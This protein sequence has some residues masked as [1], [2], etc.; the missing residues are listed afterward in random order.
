MKNKETTQETTQTP[1][2]QADDKE[3]ALEQQLVEYKN[4]LQRLQ[5]EFENYQKRTMR[6]Q[7]TFKA[8]ATQEL[9]K[10]LLNI[11]DD[12]ELALHNKESDA[13]RNGIELIYAKLNTFLEKQGVKKIPTNITFDPN[14]HE[15][16][17]QEPNEKPEGTILQELQSGYTIHDKVLRP[18]KVKI[19]TGG[20]P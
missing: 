1:Q 19:S 7:E 12:F 5:A 9:L 14:V 3:F 18:A 8:H 20:T 13:F 2:N 6:E 4:I 17:L 10:E 16:L 15:A 11:T